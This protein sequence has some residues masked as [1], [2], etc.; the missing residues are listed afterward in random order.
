[1]A[2][3]EAGQ[4]GRPSGLVDPQDPAALVDRA[5]MRVLLDVL[6]LGYGQPGGQLAPAMVSRMIAKVTD[7]L[8]VYTVDDAPDGGVS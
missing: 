8:D 6:Q 5:V 3:V 2:A 4:A 7:T 1:M